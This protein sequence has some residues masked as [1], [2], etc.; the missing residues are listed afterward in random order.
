MSRAIKHFFSEIIESLLK[1]R[2]YSR[3]LILLLFVIS[4]KILKNIIINYNQVSYDLD[5]YSS[6]LSSCSCR[7]SPFIPARHVVAGEFSC[8]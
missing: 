6:I 5:I 8:M 4:T 1:S 7:D 3:T 2:S